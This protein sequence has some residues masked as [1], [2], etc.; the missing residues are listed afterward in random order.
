MNV[1]DVNVVVAFFAEKHPHHDRARSWF[2]QALAAGDPF[3]MPDLVW[4]GFVRLVTNRRVLEVPATFAQ[5][6]EFA[7]SIQAQGAYLDYR[8]ATRALP[9]F[10][11][12]GTEVNA[13]V[14][15]VTDTYIA[16][17]ATTLGAA[18]VTFDRDFRKLDGV[19]IVEPA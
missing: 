7:E 14:D 16:A 5:A 11:R 4:V 9:E 18:V 6:W 15:L 12:L 17:C 13:Q 8:A 19:R 3:T 2:S 10:A 1:V